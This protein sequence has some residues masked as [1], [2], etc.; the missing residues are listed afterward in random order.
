M[1]SLHLKNRNH[2]KLYLR[3]T[4]NKSKYP[5]YEQHHSTSSHGEIE[6][7]QNSKVS[8]GFQNIIRNAIQGI[9]RYTHLSNDIQTRTKL[10]KYRPNILKNIISRHIIS[11]AI[12]LTVKAQ[13]ISKGIKTKVTIKSARAKCISIISILDGCFIRRFIRYFKK[14]VFAI[15]DIISRILER[16]LNVF[17]L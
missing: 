5:S 6:R 15:P 11:P 10:D 8:K 14:F 16:K 3:N 12:H 2:L 13:E 17:R 9:K 4:K 1:Y 7:L